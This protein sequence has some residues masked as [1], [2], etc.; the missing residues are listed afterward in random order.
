MNMDNIEAILAVAEA[1]SFSGA[2]ELLYV[3]Q[4]TISHRVKQLEA[5]LNTNLVQ[6]GRGHRSV[7]LTL[8]GE[9]FINIAQQWLNLDRLTKQFCKR[10][11]STTL[12]I[13][14]V[15]WISFYPFTTFYSS[16][17]SQFPDLKISIKTGRSEQIIDAVFDG[18]LDMGF[19]MY[20]G[21]SN[22]LISKPIFRDP[23]VFVCARHLL[24]PMQKVNPRDLTP[25]KE[26]FW[27]YYGDSHIWH[28]QWWEPAII[29]DIQIDFSPQ[30]SFD[31][32][33]DP[34]YWLVSPRSIAEAQVAK[35]TNLA[36]HDFSVPPPD[37]V[38][39]CIFPQT[40]SKSK[41]LLLHQIEQHIE[42]NLTIFTHEPYM[43]I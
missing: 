25:Q 3:S 22:K 7:V 33:C 28:D 20:P 17:R 37:L 23:L 6:R 21:I 15:D 43:H 8:Q 31:F 26:V 18:E 4:S 12:R 16:I 24:F 40:V 27:K 39:Y 32:L 34:D 14:Q 29:P 1:Q 9:E 5:E 11:Y 10:E 42:N 2:A 19:V 30:A 41:R 13:G 36:I 38:C 35:N